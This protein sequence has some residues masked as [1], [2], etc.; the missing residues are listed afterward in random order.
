MLTD[1]RK[2]CEPYL[3]R[4]VYLRKLN[5]D[6]WASNKVVLTRTTAVVCSL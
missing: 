5:Y 4:A 6:W 2:T 3:V 1:G